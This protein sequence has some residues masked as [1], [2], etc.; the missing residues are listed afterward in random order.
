[1]MVIIFG[2]GGST[3]LCFLVLMLRAEMDALQSV[4]NAIHCVK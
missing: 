1:M 3:F 2:Q 4:S